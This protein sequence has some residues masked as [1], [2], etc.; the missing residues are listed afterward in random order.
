MEIIRTN[1]EPFSFDPALRPLFDAMNAGKTI[2]SVTC[3]AGQVNKDDRTKDFTIK[4]FVAEDY[5]VAMQS[6]FDL[7]KTFDWVTTDQEGKTQEHRGTF[8]MS[9]VI[10]FELY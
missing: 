5:Y 10:S 1:Q 7:S 4:D 3:F 2:K 8:Y 9:W 6:S